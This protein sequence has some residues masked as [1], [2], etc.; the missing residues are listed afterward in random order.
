MGVFDRFKKSHEF[1]Q[2]SEGQLSA[3]LLG[4]NVDLEVVGE[5]CALRWN[6]RASDMSLTVRQNLVSPGGLVPS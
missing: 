1:D 5:S 3:R 2:P 4:G 6:E